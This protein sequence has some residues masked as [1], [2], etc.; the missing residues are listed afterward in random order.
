MTDKIDI[1][2]LKARAE[3]VGMDFGKAKY[4]KKLFITSCDADGD[5]TLSIE[6]ICI[7]LIGKP[8]RWDDCLQAAA[9]I[10]GCEERRQGVEQV[11]CGVCDKWFELVMLVHGCCEECNQLDASGGE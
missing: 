6:L 2:S 1:D 4:G 7:G 3:G 10:I 5:E 9:D 11:Q 8:D